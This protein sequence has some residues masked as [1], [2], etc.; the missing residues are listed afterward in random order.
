MTSGPVRERLSALL[1]PVVGAAGYD[2]ED[3]RVVPAGRRR[4]LRVV[5][6]RDEGVSLDDAAELSRSV[7]AALD[8]AD[9]MGAAPYVL[10]VTSPGV[11]RPLAVPRHWRRAAGRLVRVSLRD[12]DELTGRVEQADEI[13]VDLVVG[14]QSRRLAYDEIARGHVQVEF[15]AP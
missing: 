15:R 14:E 12:G 3:V 11:D 6:D 10:E 2:L 8:E 7:S 13:G 9:A 4:M 1:E 5:V